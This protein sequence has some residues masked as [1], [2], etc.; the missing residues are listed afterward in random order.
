MKLTDDIVGNWNWFPMYRFVVIRHTKWDKTQLDTNMMYIVDD[1]VTAYMI[2]IQAK[3]NDIY[4]KKDT[5]YDWM[6][7]DSFGKDALEF[8][9]NLYENPSQPI[10]E[11]VK[12]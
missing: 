2:Y 12:V 5:L 3:E 10:A 7:Q 4:D 11:T 9:K 8:C 1:P 6:L